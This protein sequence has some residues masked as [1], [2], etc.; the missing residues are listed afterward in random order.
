MPVTAIALTYGSFGDIMET[1]RIAKRIIDILRTGGAS[2]KHQKII[3]ILK[4]MH[5]DMSWLSTVSNVDS[6]SPAVHHRLLAETALCRSL[7][8]KFYAKINPSGGVFGK[9]WMALSE[10]KQLES[11]R[12]EISERRDSF[13]RLLELL[14]WCVFNI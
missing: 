13:H 1:A 2:H 7:L 3:S 8:D 11:W 5:D 10:E 4:A 6:S 14:N 12:T 9:I